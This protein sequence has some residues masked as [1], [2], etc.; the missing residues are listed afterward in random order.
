MV[1]IKGDERNKVHW[2]LRIITELYPGRDSKVKTV[3]LRAGKSY[4]E[5]AIQHLYPLELSCDI[6]APTQE[7]TM[8]AE[9]EEF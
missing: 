4:L 7:H 3:R 9:A 6:T 5:R 2:K 1:V 8:N